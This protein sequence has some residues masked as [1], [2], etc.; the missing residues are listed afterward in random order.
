MPLA[1]SQENYALLAL[2][3][4]MLLKLDF[5]LMGSQII[6]FQSPKTAIKEQTY[7]YTFNWQPAATPNS[8]STFSS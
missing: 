5:K 1:R 3:Y 7:D 6:N 2:Q 4:K 8:A